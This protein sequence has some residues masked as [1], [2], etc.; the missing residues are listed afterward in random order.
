MESTYHNPPSCKIQIPVLV[1]RRSPHY[2]PLGI[3]FCK[4]KY[5]KKN[6]QQEKPEEQEKI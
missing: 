2:S 1:L 5:Q 6:K 4:L 3:S